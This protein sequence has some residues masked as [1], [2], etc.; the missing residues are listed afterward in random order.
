[1]ISKLLVSQFQDWSSSLPHLLWSRSVLVKEGWEV[2]GDGKGDLI[3]V[4]WSQTHQWNHRECKTSSLFLSLAL[5][6]KEFMAPEVSL[7]HLLIC[8]HFDSWAQTSLFKLGV[9]I[10]QLLWVA[11]S[12]P[13][14]PAATCFSPPRQLF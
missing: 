3:Q 14:L 1:M 7:L 13:D 12:I 11:G 5:P 2:G 4:S 6:S 8:S 9:H 10:E